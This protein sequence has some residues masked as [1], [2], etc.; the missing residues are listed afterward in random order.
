MRMVPR[1]LISRFNLSK[2]PP[3]WDPGSGL[4]LAFPSAFALICHLDIG[5]DPICTMVSASP[6][7]GQLH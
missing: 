5:T 1:S 6:E 4:H 7:T 2:P 3:Y